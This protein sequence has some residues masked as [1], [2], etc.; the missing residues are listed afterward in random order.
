MLLWH[1]TQPSGCGCCGAG[2][3][4]AGAVFGSCGAGCVAG[5]GVGAGAAPPFASVPLCQRANA[6]RHRKTNTTPILILPVVVDSLLIV[7]VSKDQFCLCKERVL[8]FARVWRRR[9]A[10]EIRQR[11]I[12]I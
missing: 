9:P 7:F 1:F 4:G 5:V 2:L 10:A 6:T 11:A 12:L 3:G 8:R